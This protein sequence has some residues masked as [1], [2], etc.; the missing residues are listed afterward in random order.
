MS[1][2]RRIEGIAGTT[3]DFILEVSKS[4]HPYEFIGM[5][6][7]DGEVISDVLLLPG[8]LSSDRNASIRLDMMPLGISYIGSV[9]NH[10]YPGPGAERPSAQDLFIFA[11]TGNCHIITFYPYDGDCWRCYNSKGEDRGLKIMEIEDRG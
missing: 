6:S 5:L 10:P 2:R 9:H 3:L 11:R 1:K 4:Y 7:A 8:M